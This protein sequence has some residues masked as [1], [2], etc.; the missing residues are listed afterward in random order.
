MKRLV[1]AVAV[2]AL[3]ACSSEAPEA[4]DTTSATVPAVEAAPMDTGMKM[5]SMA[6]VDSTAAATTDSTKA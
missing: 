1:L 2:V 5:D 6:P 4:A 3:A